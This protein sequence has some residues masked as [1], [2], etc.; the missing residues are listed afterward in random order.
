LKQGVET[1]LKQHV[2]ELARV[3][4]QTDHSNTEGA[5]FK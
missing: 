2:P 5:Y 1:T 4:D 3:V